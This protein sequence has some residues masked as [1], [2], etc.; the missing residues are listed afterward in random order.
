MTCDE[1]HVMRVRPDGSHTLAEVSAMGSH[2]R[3]CS[4]CKAFL[5]VTM[6]MNRNQMGAEEFDKYMQYGEEM[7]ARVAADPELA[8]HH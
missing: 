2:V 7:A 8:Y 6:I 3:G 4:T 1:Y 5:I